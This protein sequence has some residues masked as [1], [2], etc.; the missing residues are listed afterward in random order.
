MPP[1]PWYCLRANATI[2][3][4]PLDRTLRPYT[5][6]LVPMESGTVHRV[7]NRTGRVI[8]DVFAHISVV[9]RRLRHS[10]GPKL[11]Q[12][13]HWRWIKHQGLEISL[14]QIYQMVKGKTYDEFG[15]NSPE[16]SLEVRSQVAWV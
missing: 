12:S 10:T 5:C 8:V 4:S 14:E 9:F 3:R 1:C 6:R 7:S 11:G 16:M 2:Y 13:T 15:F